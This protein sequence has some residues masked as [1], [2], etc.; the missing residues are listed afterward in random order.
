MCLDHPGVRVVARRLHVAHIVEGSVRRVA[1]RAR[2]T[3]QLVD[4]RNGFQLWSER[5]D[6]EMAHVFEI[7]DDIARSIAGRLKVA[8]LTGARRPTSNME[9][10]ELYLRG[11][12]EL[13][14]RSR[15]SVN[16]GLLGLVYG[17]AGRHEDAGRLLEELESRA[18]QGQ[19]SIGLAR[20]TL[21]L[22]NDDR[23][24]V[25][26]GFTAALA[27]GAGA[28]HVKVACG[29]FIESY[30]SDFE[31]DRLHRMVYGW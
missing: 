7:Q 5:Y 9:A 30:R 16:V 8:L 26:T 24:R 28:Y 13:H 10:Y 14:Q 1:N 22:G 29:P 11:R 23:D 31:V 17:R 2:V 18:A 3:A 4:V 21:E 25:R 19:F 12:Y 15:T 6:R 20:L 27:D